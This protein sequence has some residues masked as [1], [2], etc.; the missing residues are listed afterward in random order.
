M[1]QTQRQRIINVLIENREQGLNSYF[2]TYQ[3][4]IKQAP[5]RIWEIKKEGYR[6]ITIPQKDG[7]VNWILE[8]YPPKVVK[9][10]EFEGANAKVTEKT[11]RE[12][13]LN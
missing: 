5:T 4:R 2:A 11:I 3:M 7:S 10:Y 8:A 12:N 6:I 9:T 1:K 13:L